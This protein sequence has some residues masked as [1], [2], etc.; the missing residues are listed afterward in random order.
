MW[1]FAEHL[2]LN[3]R[4]SGLLGARWDGMDLSTVPSQPLPERQLEKRGQNQARL[5]HPLFSMPWPPWAQ[6]DYN[7][8]TKICA[9]LLFIPIGSKDDILERCLDVSPP[10]AVCM[11]KQSHADQQRLNSKQ[12]LHPVCLGNKFNT[13]R[14]YRQDAWS[15]V[16]FMNILRARRTQQ[17]HG[18]WR[19]LC[20]FALP[21]I[22]LDQ[23]MPHVSSGKLGWAWK[24]Y[25]N[26]QPRQC[27]TSRSLHLWD[28]WRFSGEVFCRIK[29]TLALQDW[30]LGDTRWSF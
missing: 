19:W 12:A 18:A 23:G 16:D 29:V 11:M 21:K 8:K 25:Q 3:T 1:K 28:G 15:P 7:Q 2:I 14:A 10:G 13:L 9:S 22:L 30:T 4:Q 17:E 6:L 26:S 20:E 27:L 5:L 24:A